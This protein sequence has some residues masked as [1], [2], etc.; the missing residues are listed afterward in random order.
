LFHH[1]YPFISLQGFLRLDKEWWTGLGE[2]QIG[3]VVWSLRWTPS[4]MLL[5][6]VSCHFTQKARVVGG[7]VDQDSDSLGQGRRYMWRIGSVLPA[8]GSTRPIVSTS[9]GWHLRQRNI[10]KYNMPNIHHLYYIAE[11]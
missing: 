8:A 10:W 6:L 11:L 5:K 2:L 1:P 3:G 4:F 9:S 7:G